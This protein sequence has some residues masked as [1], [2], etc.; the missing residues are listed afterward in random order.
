MGVMIRRRLARVSPTRSR[1]ERLL[2]REHSVCTPRDGIGD[3]T[4]AEV[5]DMEEYKSNI[6]RLESSRVRLET[7][8]FGKLGS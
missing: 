6:R 7:R 1:N 3:G 4:V 2:S 5:N 8:D